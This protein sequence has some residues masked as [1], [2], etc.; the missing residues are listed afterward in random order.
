M[1]SPLYMFTFVGAFCN[2]KMLLLSFVCKSLF[3]Y[4]LSLF[5]F[6]QVIYFPFHSSFLICKLFPLA[7]AM[8]FSLFSQLG[9]ARQLLLRNL[10]RLFRTSVPSS[11]IASLIASMLLLQYLIV[12][13]TDVRTLLNG[14][15]FMLLLEL[16]S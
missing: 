5:Y 13:L 15:Y 14:T 1:F 10:R 6:S 7:I 2:F 16:N 12:F 11:S 3:L 4:L 9:S 8:F